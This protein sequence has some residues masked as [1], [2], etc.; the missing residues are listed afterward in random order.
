MKVQLAIYI[1][2]TKHAKKTFIDL[3][4]DFL[5]LVLIHSGSG[6]KKMTE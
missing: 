5:K 4:E 3:I 2:F 1:T 6:A